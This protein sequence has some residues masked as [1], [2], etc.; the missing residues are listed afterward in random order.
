MGELKGTYKGYELWHYKEGEKTSQEVWIAVSK[1]NR[2]EISG[3]KKTQKALKKLIDETLDQTDQKVETY[4][5]VNIVLSSKTGKYMATLGSTTR[6]A[7]DLDELKK[8][9]DKREK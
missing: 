7:D 5:G 1:G 6:K 2:P 8:W 3:L 9:I 4:K